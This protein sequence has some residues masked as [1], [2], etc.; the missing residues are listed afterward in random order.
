MHVASW[1]KSCEYEYGFGGGGAGARAA[2]VLAEMVQGR[3]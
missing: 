2:M 1:F 3:L